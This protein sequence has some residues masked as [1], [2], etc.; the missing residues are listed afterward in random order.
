MWLVPAAM[1]LMQAGQNR[2]AEEQARK[3]ARAKMRSAYLHRLGYPTDRIDA[4]ETNQQL[5]QQY[6]SQNWLGPAA[7]QTF[8]SMR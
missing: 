5:E 4:A 3:D 6:G 7:L 8:A 2:Q 1:T